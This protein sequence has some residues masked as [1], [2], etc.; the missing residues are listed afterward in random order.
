MKTK[1]EAL[2]S[3]TSH[4]RMVNGCIRTVYECHIGMLP[5]GDRIRFGSLDEND[6]KDKIIDYYKRAAVM[7]DTTLIL[8]PGQVYEAKEALQ[9]IEEAGCEYSLLEVVKLFL[10]GKSKEAVKKVTI[11]V[12]YEEYVRTFSANQNAQL[13]CLAHRVKPWVY[14][15]GVE[16]YLS[17]V[18]IEEFDRYTSS[19]KK[20][21]WKDGKIVKSRENISTR[22]RNGVISYCGSFMR[23]CV[24]KGYIAENPLAKAK[25]EAIAYEE[26]DYASVESVKRLFEELKSFGHKKMIA[27][28]ALSFFC[29]IRAA[30]IER[31]AQDPNAFVLEDDTIRISTPKGYT[32]GIMPRIIKVLPNAKAW[33][34]YS[35]APHVIYEGAMI[36]SV[37]ETM[38]RL[39]KKNGIPFSRN[40]G[41]HSFIT[42]H[43]AAFQ[44]PAK[45]E[46]LAGTSGRMRA[47]HYMG[48][49]TVAQGKEY[50][51][52]YP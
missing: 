29:G 47:H 30:E 21:T 27:Y 17:A 49:A 51:N 8:K 19:L 35:D 45:T 33:L 1:R 46:A 41:R 28:A 5:N 14:A 40:D 12:A 13:H 38:L 26:P 3:I 16:R 24:E 10:K 6:L 39:M 32:R 42:Y 15:F 34:L 11:G 43:V 25:T 4:Q 36:S 50:F 18:T 48:L 22:T 7:G 44:D 52:I 23:W 20:M 2:A 9:L 37:R 31:M